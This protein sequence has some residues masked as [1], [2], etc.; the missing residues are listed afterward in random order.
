[1][2]HLHNLSYLSRNINLAGGAPFPD[3]IAGFP[4]MYVIGG[5]VGAFLLLILIIFMFSGSSNKAAPNAV[6]SNVG[7][8]NVAASNVAAS[9]VAA[10]NAA[11]PN[12]AA[13]NVAVATMPISSL[14]IG[15]TINCSVGDPKGVKPDGPNVYGY[16]GGNTINYYPTPAVGKILDPNWSQPSLIN[17]TGLVKGP[18]AIRGGENETANFN[19][20]SGNGVVSGTIIY[21]NQPNNVVPYSI[22]SGTKN[23]QVS[24]NI[25]GKDPNPG[26]VKSWGA[27]YTC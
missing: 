11:A 1:M 4:A 16:A 8:S 6:A 3:E 14:P 5:A 9:N 22:P 25:I 2:S 21:G 17:C 13:P 20:P 27:I 23:V 24:N 10:P 15:K 7:A 18:D 12:A 26:V 19:C